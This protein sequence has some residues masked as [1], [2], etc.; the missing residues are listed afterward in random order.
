MRKPVVSCGRGGHNAGFVQG[1]PRE[2]SLW[3]AVMRA[4]AQFSGAAEKGFLSK[5][6]G[7]GALGLWPG[8]SSGLAWKT[9]AH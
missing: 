1:C 9:V 8:R 6:R 2:P 4:C 5:R 3:P 7:L